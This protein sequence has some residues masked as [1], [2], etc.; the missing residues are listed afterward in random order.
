MNFLITGAWQQAKEYIPQIE[1]IHN[2][3][4]LQQERDELPCSSSWVQGIIGN[5]IFLFHPI[6]SF[7]DLQYI[8]LTSAGFDRVPMEYV[9]EKGIKIFNARG[10]YSI[11]MAEYALS[12]VLAFYKRQRVFVENQKL[13]TWEKERN[14]LEL[15]GKKVCVLGC[16]S[17]GTECARRFDAMGCIVR[18]IDPVV[19]KQQSFVY[20]GQTDELKEMLGDSDIVIVTL[21]LTEQTKELFNAE[22]LGSMKDGAILVNIARGGLICT[23]ALINELESGRISAALDVFEEEPLARESRLWDL[24]NVLI[25]PHNSFVGDGNARRLSGL[26][27]KNLESCSKQILK[28]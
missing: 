4:F 14:L 2:V 23:D 27:M 1:K 18:G 15:Y 17:V 20:I 10:V 24:K 5:G 13:H 12:S 3:C 11:P 26:I 8:Q 16:G 6:E 21:P 9:A 28:E 25:T 22:V 19:R 7:T